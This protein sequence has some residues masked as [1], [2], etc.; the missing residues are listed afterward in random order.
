MEIIEVKE[1]AVEKRLD[2]VAS[3]F[4][5]KVG[6]ET[7]PWF[8]LTWVLLWLYTFLTFF[9]MFFRPDFVNLT[10]CT[11]ALFMMFTPH[12]ITKTRFRFL[13]LTIMLSLIYDL[14]W[15]FMMH[16]E[17]SMEPKSDGSGEARIRKFSL[18]ASYASFLLRVNFPFL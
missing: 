2:A 13:V 6:Y 18:M 12:R 16:A 10:I 14:V 15:F 3:R 7:V 8:Q 9:V 17:Y 11:T 5:K 4:A 1:K